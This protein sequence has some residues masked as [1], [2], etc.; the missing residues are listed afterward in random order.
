MF[1][2]SKTAFLSAIFTAALL[3]PPYSLAA[4]TGGQ[5]GASLGFSCNSKTGACNCDGIATSK[6]CQ[7]MEK[8]CKNKMFCGIPP[9]P[10]FQGEKKCFCNMYFPKARSDLPFLR[11]QRQKQFTAPGAS[12][13]VK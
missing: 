5:G 13:I 8:N 7:N 4:Q 12:P 11:L 6:D 3:H 10:P 1:V 9:T 2:L